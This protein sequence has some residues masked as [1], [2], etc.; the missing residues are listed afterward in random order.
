MNGRGDAPQKPALQQ[1]LALKLAVCLVGSTA[2]F[3][4]LAGY[5]NLRYEQRSF[6]GFT[7]LSA[8]RVADIILRSTRHEM[9][10]NDRG[11]LLV[12][13]R[14]IGSEPGIKRIRIFNK[15]GL[16]TFSTDS[17]EIGT[18]VNKNAEAC[19]ACHAREA[20]LV[21]LNRPDRA[22]IFQSPSEGRILAVIRPIE[23]QP[24]CW[25][26]SCHVHPPNKRVLGVVDVHLSLANVDEQL[27]Q[28]RRRTALLL[29]LTAVLF[30][31]LSVVFVWKVV[32]KP[33]E[34]LRQGTIR[35][36]EGDLDYRL[37]VHSNDELG[38]LA[39]SFNKMTADLARAREELTDWARTLE[40]RVRRKTEELERAQA[41]LIA[42]A[43]MASL[44][45]LAATVAHEVNNP[46][47]GML[48]YARLTMKTLQQLPIDPAVKAQMMDNL[49]VVERESRRCGDIMKNLLAYARQTK[50]QRAPAELNSLV[51]RSVKLVRHQLELQEIALET[52]L[53]PA[54][55]EIF[56]DPG[57]IQ[58]VLII[59][60]VNASEAMAKGG[61]L[62][63]ATHYDPSSRTVAISVKDTGHGIPPEILS[64]IFEPFFTTKENQ[65]RTGLG[66]A[67]AKNIV[68][69]H[70]GQIAVDSEQGKGTEFTVT[71][72]V[73][74]PAVTAVQPDS[75][76]EAG[77]RNTS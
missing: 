27:A 18:M 30:S 58:Q 42:S 52:H 5:F 37:T 32:H 43:K 9:L 17:S 66:L 65:H 64:Q 24:D 45:K 12:H 59:L 55:P 69:Q 29:V 4:G 3:F 20:P 75:A 1:R 2:G 53:D 76:V 70:G 31:C 8:D 33:I 21:R 46:L 34:E 25:S 49:K 19:Y 57:Q 11:S 7:L 62:T 50:P 71:L 67:I 60:M 41:S 23:N 63:V 38:E 28:N 51:D 73:D 35:V 77:G 39:E 61:K 22:R 13:I 16:I 74:A 10:V 26:A 54:T 72:P 48:T 40:E 68:E 14:N 36:A 6:E 56:C 15:E 47:F 44:G